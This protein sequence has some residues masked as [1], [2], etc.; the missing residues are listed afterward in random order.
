MRVK[1]CTYS[2]PSRLIGEKVRVHVY[3]DRLE[4]YLGGALQTE[5]QR[6]RGKAARTF[7]GA[8]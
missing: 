5:T 7:A 6:V 3:D 4:V 2:V 8:T 1:S